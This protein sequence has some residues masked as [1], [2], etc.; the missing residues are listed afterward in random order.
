MS[1]PLFEAFL[2]RIY[3]DQ[4]ARDSFLRDP[5]GEARRAGLTTPECTALASIDR[6]G[7]LLAATSFERKRGARPNA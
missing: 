4:V 6:A 1:S 3:V 2:A 5:V 7:L